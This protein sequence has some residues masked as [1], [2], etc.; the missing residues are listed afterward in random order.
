MK[1][2]IIISLLCA[3]AQ[4]NCSEKENFDDNIAFAIVT[5]IPIAIAGSLIYQHYIRDQN[6]R[7]IEEIEQERQ[8]SLRPNTNV[9]MGSLSLQ[10]E[11]EKLAR[12]KSYLEKKDN[13]SDKEKN[14]LQYAQKYLIH[15]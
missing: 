8:Y 14:V 13:L 3:T 7:I 1:N 9:Y 11:Q 5:A 2:T 15:E 12:A 6:E 4:I 10:K